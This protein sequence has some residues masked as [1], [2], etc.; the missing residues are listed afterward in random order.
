MNGSTKYRGIGYSTTNLG[1]G[2]WRWTLHPEKEVG[3][4]TSVIFGEIAGT[5]D[6]A[7]AAAKK[8]IDTQMSKNSN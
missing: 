2:R 7:V 5:R 3:V 4:L 6:K 8:E 1:N